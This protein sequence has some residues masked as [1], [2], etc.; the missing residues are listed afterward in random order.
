MSKK[1]K[2]L[3]KEIKQKMNMFD[4]IEETCLACEKPF[5]KKDK[6]MVSSWFVVVR[7]DKVNLYC[8]HCWG[9]AQ[10]IIKEFKDASKAVE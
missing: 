6:E 1:D 3:E 2:R 10:K 8:P 4:K 7:E 9:T 5:N